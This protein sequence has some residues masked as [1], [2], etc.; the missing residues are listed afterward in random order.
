VVSCNSSPVMRRAQWHRLPVGTP[1]PKA[2]GAHVCGF[3]VP[4][5]FADDAGLL[6]EPGQIAGIILTCSFGW[7]LP[8]EPGAPHDLTNRVDWTSRTPEIGRL[9]CRA[10]FSLALSGLGAG[11][12][13]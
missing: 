13:G 10:F 9:A 6:P 1:L 4:G 2:S 12:S 3:D 7:R 5:G 8:V 11:T